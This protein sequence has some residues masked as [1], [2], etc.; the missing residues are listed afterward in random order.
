MDLEYVY[1]KDIKKMIKEGK[2]INN[3]NFK[4]VRGFYLNKKVYINL[5]AIQWKHALLDGDNLEKELVDTIIH[6]TT[7]K[8][9]DELGVS[10]GID[11][12][13]W[14]CSVMAGQIEPK[15][16]IKNKR[17]INELIYNIFGEDV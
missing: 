6:E 3:H 13:E 9:L 14:A 4:E 10:S 17:F 1:L 5:S 12:E 11:G 16:C 2:V 15:S 8:V 7:H